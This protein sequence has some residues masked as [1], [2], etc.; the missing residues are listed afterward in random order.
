MI[1]KDRQIIP[2]VILDRS[3]PGDFFF[4]FTYLASLCLFLGFIEKF[5]L[6]GPSQSYFSVNIK[7]ILT[8]TTKKSELPHLTLWVLF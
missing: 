8:T 1:K 7:I 4:F 2:E 6:S 5:H 3:A